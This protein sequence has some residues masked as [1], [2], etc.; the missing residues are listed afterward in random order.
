MQRTSKTNHNKNKFQSHCDGK[1]VSEM[2]PSFVN[3]GQPKLHWWVIARRRQVNL[4]LMSMRFTG[5][6]YEAHMVPFLFWVAS[7]YLGNTIFR[8]PFL[9]NDYAQLKAG[10]VFFSCKLPE[11]ASGNW[12]HVCGER[13][14]KWMCVL[15][16]YPRNIHD[17]VRRGTVLPYI[18]S[19]KTNEYLKFILKKMVYILITLYIIFHRSS[20]E[21]FLSNI[22]LEY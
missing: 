14:R 18:K 22:C 19:L 10:V 20:L 13:L 6:N 17:K 5:V 8:G 16:I 15:G 21:Y 3:P 2:G 4:V 11:R 9:V 12:Q 1:G 7:Q